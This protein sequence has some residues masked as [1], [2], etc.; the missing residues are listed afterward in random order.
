MPQAVVPRD[1]EFFRSL[2]RLFGRVRRLEVNKLGLPLAGTAIYSES[3]SPGAGLTWTPD[4]T[5]AANY[6]G[7]QI[8]LTLYGAGVEVPQGW[9][10][11]VTV[12]LEL[13]CTTPPAGDALLW[14]VSV[15]SLV[16]SQADPLFN[17]ATSVAMTVPAPSG[18]AAG[19]PLPVQVGPVSTGFG[20]LFSPT[21]MVVQ[22]VAIQLPVSGWPV[23][24]G[25]S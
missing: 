24:G 22:A 21:E 14:S 18:W 15:G 17:G 7:D 20:S 25:P 8:G 9:I 16:L 3:Y 2:N 12:Q 1:P 13:S 10:A 5:G 19:G 23:G 6:G 4:F 11:W